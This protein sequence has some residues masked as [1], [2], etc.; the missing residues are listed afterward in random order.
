MEKAYNAGFKSM[1]LNFM[2]FV[3]KIMWIF[4]RTKCDW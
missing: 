4:E 2:H 3:I 1:M